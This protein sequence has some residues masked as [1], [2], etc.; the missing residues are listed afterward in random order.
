MTK[1]HF[2]RRCIKYYIQ[3]PKT[4]SVDVFVENLPGLPDNIRYDGQ[5]LYWVA[6]FTVSYMFLTLFGEEISFLVMHVTDN[7]I[8]NSVIFFFF[9]FNPECVNLS[10]FL[11]KILKALQNFSGINMWTSLDTSKLIFFI[12]YRTVRQYRSL[13]N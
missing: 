11:L 1:F 5:G 6:L 12:C 10:H 13:E 3:G 7:F 9:N 2:R 4:G 8:F